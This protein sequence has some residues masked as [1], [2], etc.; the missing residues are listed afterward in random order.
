[1]PTAETGGTEYQSRRLLADRPVVAVKSLLAGVAVEPRGRLTR[2]VHFDQPG[3]LLREEED[4]ASQVLRKA[5]VTLEK[6]RKLIK[7]ILAEGQTRSAPEPEQ[8]KK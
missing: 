7:Q 1:M 5:G 4:I 6:A 3:R 2:S 8:H